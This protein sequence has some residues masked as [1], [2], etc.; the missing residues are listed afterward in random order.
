MED[1]YQDYLED[2]EAFHE[3]HAPGNQTTHEK[4]KAHYARG[5]LAYCDRCADIPE[6]GGDP[7]E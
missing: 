1:D 6:A 4:F 3:W 2:P 7:Y 5:P